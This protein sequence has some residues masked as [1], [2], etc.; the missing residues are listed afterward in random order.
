MAKR[1]NSS[2]S[3]VRRKRATGY[4]YEAFTPAQYACN[5]EGR[6][7]YHREL[8][9]RFQ[10]RAEAR[11]ALDEYIKHPTTKYNFTLR[12]LYEEWKTFAFKDIAKQ[13][14]DNYTAAWAK[15]CACDKPRI[16]DKMLREITTGELRNILIYFQDL[17]KLLDLENGGYIIDKETKEPKHFPA[18]SRSYISKI[19]ALLTQLYTYGE[20]NHIVDRNYAA[21]VKL[22]RQAKSKKRSFTDLEFATLEKGWKDVP[23]GDAVYALCYLGF[24]VTE[25]CELTHF[26]YDPKNQLI[27]GGLKTDAGR[28]R[29][30]PVHKKIQPIVKAWYDRGCDA[31]YADKNGKH[32][33]KDR[34]LRN[35]WRPA[36]DALGLPE[37]LTPHSA[38]HT[39]ATRL[40]AAGARPED[41]KNIMGHEDYSLT[42]N[43]YVNQDTKAL[44]DAME[45]LA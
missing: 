36:L 31:L 42:A 11:A 40:S 43:T 24:R 23:G 12:D 7:I 33:N 4:I 15:I 22:T 17:H 39:C 14:Q 25:F 8:I 6:M 29:V 18:L 2:G 21:L 35:V 27:S 3:I 34:F 41:I 38:R 20:E 10:K 45:L 9:G 1:E 37:D 30:V 13:T 16:A 5:E 28:D 26:S 32:Y 44:T 19:K